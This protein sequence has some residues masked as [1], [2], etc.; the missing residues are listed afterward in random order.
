[1]ART[2]QQRTK[3]RKAKRGKGPP[4]SESEDEG[5]ASSDDEEID[6]QV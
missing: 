3:D 6:T 4:Q 5:L 2:K 1:M